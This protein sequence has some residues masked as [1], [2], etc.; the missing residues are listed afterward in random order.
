LIENGSGNDI[1]ELIIYGVYRMNE[2]LLE[3]RKTKG[4]SQRDFC[5]RLGITQSTYAPMETGKREIRDAYIKLIAVEYGVNENWLR[6]GTGEM[7]V[8]KTD[9]GLQELLNAYDN[10]TPMLK[11]FLLK[12]A[13]DLRDLQMDMNAYDSKSIDT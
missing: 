7:F 2:R 10:L 12:Q 8:D 1:I 6:Y 9:I 5:K 11:S 3:I 4:L 13:R